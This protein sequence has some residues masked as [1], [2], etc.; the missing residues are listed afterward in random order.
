MRPPSEAFKLY[1]NTPLAYDRDGV[2]CRQSC[3]VNGSSSVKYSLTVVHRESRISF[4]PKN[5]DTWE[6]LLTWMHS[7]QTVDVPPL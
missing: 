4:L 5:I 1:P 3:S 2:G 6:A 7:Q